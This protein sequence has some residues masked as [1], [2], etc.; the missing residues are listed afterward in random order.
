MTSP[1]GDAVRAAPDAHAATWIAPVLHSFGADVG[2]IAPPGHDRYLRVEDLGHGHPGPEGDDLVR[3]LAAVLAQH[4]ATP[5]HAWFAIWEGY[6]WLSGTTLYFH[7]PGWRGLASRLHR[8]RADRAEAARRAPLQATLA[9]LPQLQ[10]PHRTYHLLSGPVT[11]VNGIV[12]P[13]AVD[14][15]QVPDLW[16]PD[17]RA[18]FV[19][20]DT[21]LDWTYVGGTVALSDALLA[22]LPERARP[23]DIT[24]PI[25]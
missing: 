10:L 16:W 22:A 8:R 23:V 9:A 25:E 2:A 18:W 3:R 12:E 5:H 15:P 4:T 13:G 20:T 17:D 19:A 6:G 21:D 11:A 7:P 14:R 1:F 24:D